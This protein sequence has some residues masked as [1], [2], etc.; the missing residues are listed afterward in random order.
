MYDDDNDDVIKNKKLD[1]PE[2]TS[3]DISP[4]RSFPSSRGSRAVCV[5]VTRKRS[6][7]DKSGGHHP[8]FFV[9]GLLRTS[10]DPK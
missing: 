1:L 10:P 5:T 6:S 3:L 9:S 8:P 4:T 2:A 7:K